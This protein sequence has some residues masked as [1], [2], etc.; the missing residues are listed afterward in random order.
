MSEHTYLL[1]M[2]A[3]DVPGASVVGMFAV[4]VLVA[5]VCGSFIYFS[6]LID[7]FPSYW[8][9]VL[10]CEFL[11]VSFIH[12]SLLFDEAAPK[13]ELISS[14]G[15]HLF[16]ASHLLN[17][18]N[19]SLSSIKSVSSF[20][21]FIYSHAIWFHHFRDHDGSDM[22]TLIAFYFIMVWLIPFSL[23]MSL[24]TSDYDLPVYSPSHQLGL[25]TP[26]K[27]A[28]LFPSFVP[29]KSPSPRDGSYSPSRYGSASKDKC[30]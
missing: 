2:N 4:I 29:E 22:L 13:F 17:Y 16:Y 28:S 26:S 30:K 27:S 6:E 24:R 15:C 11:A 20:I 7:Q 8:L 19:A 12:I 25:M 5:L 9:V 18:P 21:A 23:A 1:P 3:D 14:L 10:K